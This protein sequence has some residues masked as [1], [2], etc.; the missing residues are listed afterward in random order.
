VIAEDQKAFAENNVMI[1]ETSY[2]L[3]KKR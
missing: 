3:Q 1:A 2:A